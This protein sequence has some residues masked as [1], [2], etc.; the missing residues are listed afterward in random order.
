MSGVPSDWENKF[1]RLID[2]DGRDL[3]AAWDKLCSAGASETALITMLHDLFAE[4]RVERKQARFR[5]AAEK[6]N[7]LSCQLKKVMER[8][9]EVDQA[10]LGCFEPSEQPAVRDGLRNSAKELPGQLRRR[11]S[12]LNSVASKFKDHSN[13][14]R[15]HGGTLKS[16]DGLLTL[17][18]TYL[19]L[20]TGRAHAP[21]IAV[22]VE[23]AAKVSRSTNIPNQITEDWVRNTV[24]RYRK[25]FSRNVLA[26]EA[27]AAKFGMNGVIAARGGQLS[28]AMRDVMA[29]VGQAIKSRNGGA[30][31][32]SVARLVELD[33]VERDC[34]GRRIP[35]PATK[36]V[37]NR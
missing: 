14:K 23:A 34:P 18:A 32:A 20:L 24:R 31:R 19:E 9:P 8:I 16:R 30:I 2:H 3:K 27:C 4:D 25:E 10:I 28:G 37:R 26:I 7:E 11:I 1:R 33:R 5:A 12:Q 29:E 17:L 21:E 35:D 36:S 15:R 13:R 6:A 22:L